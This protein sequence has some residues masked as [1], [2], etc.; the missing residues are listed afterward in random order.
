MTDYDVSMLFNADVKWDR[1]S[2]AF[3]KA[4]HSD[5]TLRDVAFVDEYRG[6]QVPDGKKVRDAP[7]VHR[8]RPKDSTS[9]EIESAAA[10]VIRRLT[11]TPGGEMRTK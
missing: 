4:Q 11:K 6:G 1:I 10:S 9:Q 5:R 2:E 3:A 8:L 7:S